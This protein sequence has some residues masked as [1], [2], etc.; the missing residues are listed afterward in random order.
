MLSNAVEEEVEAATLLQRIG[1]PCEL[2][3]L[4]LDVDAR[5]GI[6]ERDDCRPSRRPFA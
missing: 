4:S 5:G 1:D 2:K 6:K 3:L